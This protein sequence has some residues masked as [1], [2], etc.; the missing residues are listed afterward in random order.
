MPKPLLMV[1]KT[2]TT[3][4]AFRQ[5]MSEKNLTIIFTAIYVLARIL[6]FSTYEYPL[7]NEII[8]GILTAIFFV[9]CLKSTKLGW[10]MLVAE[11]LLDGAGR[12]F[13]LRELLL[14]TWFLG[15]FSLVW[16]IS[17][18]I[19]KNKFVL[20]TRK[21]IFGIITLITVIVWSIINGFISR[22]ATGNILQDAILYFFILLIFPAI[23]FGYQIL[24][25]LHTVVKAWLVGTTL[26]TFTTFIIYSSGIGKLQDAYYHW[27][28]DVA[29]GK[30]TDLGENFFRVTLSEHL[31]LVPIIIILCA[32]I[33]ENFKNLKLWFFNICA[34]LALTLNFTRI[35]Y[36]TLFIGLLIL[37]IRQPIKKWLPVCAITLL[38]I[39]CLLTSIN[40][41]ASGGRSFGLNFLGLKIGGLTNPQT[42]LSGVVRLL[43][44]PDIYKT[45]GRGPWLGNGLG[46]TVTYVDPISQFT[47][48]RTQFDW[49][50]LEMTAELGIIGLVIFVTLLLVILLKLK[51]LAYYPQS[52]DSLNPHLA[53]GFL[54]GGV[55]LCV[56]NITTPALFQGFGILY[57]TFLLLYIHPQ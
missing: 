41:I 23:D 25:S 26:F 40:F 9:I 19:Q 20:P 48:T 4:F 55:A 29:G 18:I 44:L 31:L 50:Y 46:A 39:P 32:L 5:D 11:L 22:H 13:E 2:L 56:I 54:A 43:M 21:E 28:R 47:V 34:L 1:I 8:A 45:I 36:L 49:G 16:L 35:Y 17:K 6:S 38:I 10:L 24:K 51:N 52:I 15:I 37:A 12:F 7:A 33:M 27:F 30:I 57:L 42:D 53:R 3:H 14:R